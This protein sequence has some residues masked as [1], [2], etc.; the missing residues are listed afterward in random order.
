MPDKQLNVVEVKTIGRLEEGFDGAV[1]WSKDVQGLQTKTGADLAFARSNA[2]LSFLTDIETFRKIY[3]R[4]TLNGTGAVGGREVYVIEA[5]ADDGRAQNLYFD[6][7]TGLLLRWDIMRESG[8]RQ[9]GVA[10]PWQN[11]IDNYADVNG[12]KVAM[13][14]R[15]VLAG[16]STLTVRYV[17][18]RYNEPVDDAIFRKPSK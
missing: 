6:T 18:V 10:M 11:F 13:T 7:Q 14:F 4:F 1:A 5:M 17:D 9:Q 2:L 12:V 15:Q 3:P 8:E 16:N